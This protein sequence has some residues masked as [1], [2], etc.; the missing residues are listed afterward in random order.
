MKNKIIL[1]D[2][3]FDGHVGQAS[4]GVMEF[5]KKADNRVYRYS[6]ISEREFRYDKRWRKTKGLT[7]EEKGLSQVRQQSGDGFSGPD[8]RAEDQSE[9]H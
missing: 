9:N 6:R 3:P 7:D 4:V 8:G 5:W 1:I 2:G